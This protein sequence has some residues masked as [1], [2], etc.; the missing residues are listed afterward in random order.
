MYFSGSMTLQMEYDPM[1]VLGKLAK[2][3]LLMC[4]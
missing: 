2:L 4:V 3:G 1:D